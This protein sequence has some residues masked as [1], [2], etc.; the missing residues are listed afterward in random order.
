MIT[1][2]I[3]KSGLGI[4]IVEILAPPWVFI[5]LIRIL[6]VVLVLSLSLFKLL[7]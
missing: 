3:F 5:A 6:V 1:R 4:C 7:K 2:L